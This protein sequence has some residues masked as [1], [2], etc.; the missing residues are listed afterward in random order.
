LRDLRD[1]L[2][3]LGLPGGIERGLTAKL[4]AAE[5]TLRQRHGSSGA[6]QVLEAFVRQ[7]EALSGAQISEAARTSLVEFA[8]EI[9]GLL[10]GA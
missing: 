10:D 2:S 5:P 9:V 6:A 4:G 7:V 3:G 8:Q 1:E